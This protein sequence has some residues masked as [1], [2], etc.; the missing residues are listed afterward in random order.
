MVK[1]VLG[2]YK[3]VINSQS[4]CIGIEYQPMTPAPNLQHHVIGGDDDLDD[5]EGGT[6][7]AKRPPA[8]IPRPP[9][10]Q[11]LPDSLNQVSFSLR[12]G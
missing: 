9:S 1:Q 7:P 4:S 6:K 2:D 10:H 12:K 5:D 3:T 8:T 11:R